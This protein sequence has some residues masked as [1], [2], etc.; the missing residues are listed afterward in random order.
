MELYYTKSF[1]TC[2]NYAKSL[3]DKK[4]LNYIGTEMLLYG[5]ISTANG[6]GAHL[7]ADFGCNLDKFGYYLRKSFTDLN[8]DNY[9]PRADA[10]LRDSTQIAI[11]CKSTYI[12]DLHL[13]LAILKIE[14]CRAVAILNALGV[15]TTKLYKV[16]YNKIISDVEAY[17]LNKNTYNR[18]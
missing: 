18:V 14:D 12:S 11:D 16:V 6:E 4:K 5:I 10:A 13:L 1:E 3:R 15:D 9:T 2:L 8:I 7:L 17:N